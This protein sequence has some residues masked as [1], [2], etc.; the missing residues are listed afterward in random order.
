MCF[1]CVY[2]YMCMCFICVYVYMCIKLSLSIL[3]YLLNP[4]TGTEGAEE[5]SWRIATVCDNTSLNLFTI[6]GFQTACVDLTPLGGGRPRD[7]Y[8]RYVCVCVCVCVCI[9]PI[10]MLHMCIMCIKPITHMLHVY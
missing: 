7:V 9:K 4:P 10:D 5:G 3:Y 6:K 8:S 2:V 1:I